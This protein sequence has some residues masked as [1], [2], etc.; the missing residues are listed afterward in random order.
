MKYNKSS[1]LFFIVLTTFFIFSL[2]L[3][4]VSMNY[5][6][7]LKNLKH[8]IMIISTTEMFEDANEKS[9]QTG[10]ESASESVVKAM[11]KT[12]R[13]ANTIGKRML[14][15]AMWNER[16]HLLNKSPMDLARMHILESK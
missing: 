16:L 4:F 3:L 1:P 5:K 13:V 7:I 2:I 15:P 6:Q 9:K 8:E 11:Q 10:N 14:D 12:I